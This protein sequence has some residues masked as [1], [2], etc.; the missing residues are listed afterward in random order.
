[1]RH[2]R[3]IPMSKREAIALIAPHATA[4]LRRH[5]PALLSLVLLAGIGC[6][7]PITVKRENPRLVIRDLTSN[8]LTTGRPSL[9]SENV[10]HRWN[11]TELYDENPE[12]ALV[13][14]HNAV[15]EGRGG[16]NEV[17]ALAELSFKHAEDVRSERAQRY[18]LAT[19]VYAY[20]FLFPNGADEV[21]KRFDPRVR[22]ASDLYNRGITQAFASDNGEV[23][24]RPGSYDLSFGQ[25]VV[26]VDP[27]SLEWADR[28]LYD[29]VA[30]SDLK[31][32]GLE[33]RYRR[34]GIGAAL[35]AKTR[36]LASAP[37]G[38]TGQFLAPRAR[39]PI[40]A[41]LRIDD[42]RRRLG[43]GTLHASLETYSGWDDST[44]KIDGREVPLEVE[45][46]AAL[47]WGLADSPIWGWEL[48]GYLFGDLLHV[49][50]RSQLVFM[51]PHERGKIPVVFV[52]G[53]ASSAGRWANMFNDLLADQRIRERYEF[54]F[55]LY[56][57][58]NPIPYSAMLLRDSLQKA[59]D[60]VDPQGTDT[61]LRD[62][63]VIGHSQGGLLTKMTAIHSG[64]EFWNG[65]SNRPLE[66]LRVSDETRNL[67]RRALFVE[68]LP[69][70]HRVVFISTPHRGSFVAGYS[71]AHWVSRFI[72]LPTTVLGVM[73]DV[74]R[75]NSDALR[76]NPKHMAIG[77]VYGMTPRSPFIKALA[78]IPVAPGV[79]AHSIISVKGDGPVE[80]GDDG[81][82]KYES[83]HI[84]G[85]ESE[86]VVRSPHS[87]QDNPVTIEEVRRILLEHAEK[88]C[89]AGVVCS[90]ASVAESPETEST[91]PEPA[92]VN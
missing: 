91:Q 6:A 3:E 52:H 75:G 47:A 22:T 84:E 11:M 87:C 15:V 43:Q 42:A 88:A 46:S 26:D 7:P 37:Q 33:A 85:V 27:K 90:K 58:G 30:V 73:G 35:A 68:P 60:Q 28:E 8:V 82:V 14:L 24:L 66:E 77:A 23:A 4:A 72:T 19:A 31:V 12:Q 29:F 34:P 81:V 51:A 65:F 41:F 38:G 63:V 54:W 25:L 20:A 55:F 40:T 1:M 45:P 67:L 2:E 21:P 70:V 83:A 36:P 78:A 56:S 53:T 61:A 57:T 50:Q 5:A 39:V 80:Q 9:A 76:L 89:D 62:M 74:A 16:S 44:V 79:A 86:K 18:Y 64:D 71:I 10:L 69:F 13:E 32:T 49:E 92:R 17:F 59:V 48:K